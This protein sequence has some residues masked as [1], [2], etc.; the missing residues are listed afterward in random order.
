LTLKDGWAF[1]IVTEGTGL[2]RIGA[3]L[4]DPS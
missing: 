4:T 1:G 2:E 3:V